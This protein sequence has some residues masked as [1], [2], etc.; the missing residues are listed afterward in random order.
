LSKYR[1]DLAK[2]ILIKKFKEEE[3]TL[4]A[5]FDKISVDKKIIRTFMVSSFGIWNTDSPC[6]LP[7]GEKTMFVLMNNDK[8]LTPHSFF[9]VDHNRNALFT[10]SEQ[11]SSFFR[12][13]KEGDFSIC[14]E[15]HG[16][17]FVCNKEQFK[18]AK[19]VDNKKVFVLN[20]INPKVTCLLDLKKGLGLIN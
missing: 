20:V 5:N 18:N 14:C 1:S 17:I 13:P 8:V 10:I 9:L 4:E 6:N 19:D 7:S 16:I 11:T 15:L 2:Q 3:R 12:Y